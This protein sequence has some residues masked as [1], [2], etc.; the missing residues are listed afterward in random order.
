MSWQLA[1]I[2]SCL[3]FAALSLA[4]V[5]AGSRHGSWPRR[6]NRYRKGV[7]PKPSDKST[8]HRRAST[9]AVTR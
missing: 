2:L 4:C 1:G 3:A 9:E 5:I 8:T 7:L 6:H